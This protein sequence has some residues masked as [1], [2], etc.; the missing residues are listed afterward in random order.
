MRNV[1]I[2]DKK[3]EKQR[4]VCRQRQRLEWCLYKPRNAS[5]HWKLSE[6][7]YQELGLGHMYL[8]SIF[9]STPDALSQLELQNPRPGCPSLHMNILLTLTR[10]Y[11]PLPACPPIN[12]SSPPWVWHPVLSTTAHP[13]TLLQTPTLFCSTLWL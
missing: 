6:L 2:R 1:L 5:S 12:A 10:L 8:G 9:Q 13:F 11:T 7:W 4:A 3:G